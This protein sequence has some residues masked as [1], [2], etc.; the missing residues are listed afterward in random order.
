[1]KDGTGKRAL[2]A[3]ILETDFC[4]DVD[5]VGAMAILFDAASQYRNSPQG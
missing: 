5:D 1:M 3:V 4:S 2:P